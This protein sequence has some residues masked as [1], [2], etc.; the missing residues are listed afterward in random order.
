MKIEIGQ[1]YP[2]N[3]GTS[4]KAY[5]S[6]VIYP[7]GEKVIDCRYF[8]K[9]GNKWFSGPMKLARSKDGSKQ[10]YIPYIS[11]LDKEYAKQLKEA[12]L[13]ELLKAEENHERKTNQLQT[14]PSLDTEGYPF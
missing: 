1:Y 13:A 11:Y 12:I 6:Y 2:V 4:L 7:Q 14:Q 10:E 8:E 9:D 5:F 3:K